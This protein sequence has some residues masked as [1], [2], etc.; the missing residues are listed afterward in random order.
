MH[1]E[2]V[3]SAQTEIKNEM[4]FHSMSSYHETMSDFFHNE[5]E[6]LETVDIGEK[7]RPKL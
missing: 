2:K 3:E 4:D 7:S 5:D 6:I 1:N